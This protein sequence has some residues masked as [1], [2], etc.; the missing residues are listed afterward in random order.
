M[1]GLGKKLKDLSRARDRWEQFIRAAGQTH[2]RDAAVAATAFEEDPNFGSNPGNL[3]MF[4]YT[5]ARLAADP[6]LVVVLHGCGQTAADFNRGA[7]WATLADRYGFL[8]LLPQQRRPNNVN[9]CFNWFRPA[10][11][12]R[13]QGEALS[14]RQMIGKTIR[15]RGVDR[16]RVFIAGLSAGGAM[17]SA[18]LACYPE[19]FAGGAIISG[20]P[21]GAAKNMREAFQRMSDGADRPAS[22][23]GDLVRAAAP[24]RGPWPRISIWHGSADTIVTPANAREIVKQ[25]T[26]VHGLPVVPSAESLVD[27]YPR[28]VWINGAGD[29]LIESYA[30]THMAHGAPLATGN[31]EDKC[32]KAG[33]FLLEVGI[34]SSYHIAKFFGLTGPKARRRAEAAATETAPISPEMTAARG[35]A[36]D[37]PHTSVFDGALRDRDFEQE[38]TFD[39][40]PGARDKRLAPFPAA[41]VKLSSPRP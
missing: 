26:D 1:F 9:R 23:W 13:D 24:H 15:R 30:I 37:A 7:G 40:A 8:L 25:W 29:E 21:Y 38:R 35:P 10:D 3:R 20:L 27:G 31:A 6:A 22:T 28:K 36:A 18:M 16:R 41:D 34:S 12:A 14:I 32:G 19:I 4:T 11:T 5:P 39:R 33:P 17:T 2:A